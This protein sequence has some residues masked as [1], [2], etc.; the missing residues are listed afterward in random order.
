MAA[1]TGKSYD[2]GSGRVTRVTRGRKES[3]LNRELE[4][5]MVHDTPASHG[6]VGAQWRDLVCFSIANHGLSNEASRL[7]LPAVVVEVLS[8][9]VDT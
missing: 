8:A 4:A 6:V 9:H 3:T 2:P 1:V 5:S 7:A